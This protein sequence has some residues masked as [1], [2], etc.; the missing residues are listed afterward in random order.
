MESQS[1]LVISSQSPKGAGRTCPKCGWC[2]SGAVNRDIQA[3]CS[4]IGGNLQDTWNTWI[5]WKAIWQ[6]FWVTP[7]NHP[8]VY[9]INQG[10]LIRIF[11]DSWAIFERKRD[12]L[13][14]C[15]ELPTFVGSHHW[16]SRGTPARESCWQNASASLCRKDCHTRL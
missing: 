1:D 5:H 11:S 8:E 14:D 2:T 4:I 13:G 16:Q 12:Q 15:E 3:V 10:S 6:P 7:S 9:N